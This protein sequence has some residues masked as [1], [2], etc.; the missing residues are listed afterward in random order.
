MQ[1]PKNSTRAYANENYQCQSRD[2]YLAIL[3]LRE[4]AV[5][6][7]TVS[8]TRRFSSAFIHVDICH[9]AIPISKLTMLAIFPNLYFSFIFVLVSI[10]HNEVFI[11]LNSSRKSKWMKKWILNATLITLILLIFTSLNFCESTE[12]QSFW[13]F[14]AFSFSWATSWQYLCVC[15]SGLVLDK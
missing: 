5:C 8:L 9:F 3:S 1:L 15:V 6:K 14:R 12:R 2:L 4:V 10:I 7:S 11:S 13:K